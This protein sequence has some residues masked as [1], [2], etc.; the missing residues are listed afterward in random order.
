MSK[1][2]STRPTAENSL[3]KKSFQTPRPTDSS[4]SGQKSSQS[5]QVAVPQDTHL[6]L[7]VGLENFKPSVD[8]INGQITRN[9][10]KKYN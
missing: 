9:Q 10:N 1:K 6:N 3:G 8:G 5:N 4:S 2:N 7:Q